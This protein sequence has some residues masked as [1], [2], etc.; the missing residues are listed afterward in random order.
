MTTVIP[1]KLSEAEEQQLNE[2]LDAVVEEI[3]QRCEDE[4]CAPRRMITDGWWRE[5]ERPRLAR[6]LEVLGLELLAARVHAA[7]RARLVCV[8]GHWRRGSSSTAP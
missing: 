6:A 5:E 7:Q 1:V 3:R 8:D 4:H 2:Q